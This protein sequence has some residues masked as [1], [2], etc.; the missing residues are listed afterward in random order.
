VLGYLL[1]VRTW[2]SL[3]TR[4]FRYFPR[5][6]R[7][8]KRLLGQSSRGVRSSFAAFPEVSAHGLSAEGTS[9]GVPCPFSALGGGNPRLSRLPARA[10]PVPR[11]A[12]A[13]PTPPTTVPLTGFL[14]LPAASSSLRRPA[15][16]RQVALLGFC[17]SGVHLLARSPDGSS[18]PACPRDVPPA[19]CASPIL[20]G[21]T[22]RHSV[23]YLG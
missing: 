15:I 10:T 19:G 5:C 4:P 14:N 1:P 22:S 11:D 18:P 8:R 21:G 7:P 2:C 16:F 20:G 3:N 17:P 23:R 13:A 6:P 9:P 12:P